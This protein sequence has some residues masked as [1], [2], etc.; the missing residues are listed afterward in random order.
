[1]NLTGYHI[2]RSW[3]PSHPL[4]DECP[5]PKAECGL[6]ISET[7]NPACEQHGQTPRTMREVHTPGQCAERIASKH[8]IT[9]DIWEDA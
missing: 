5:C 7:A 3:W 8:T 4:E 2:G 6:V 9:H 1:M